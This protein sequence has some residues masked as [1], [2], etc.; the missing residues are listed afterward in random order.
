M[1]SRNNINHGKAIGNSWM[2]NNDHANGTSSRGGYRNSNHN[3]YTCLTYQFRNNIFSRPNNSVTIR[4][5]SALR[6]VLTQQTQ[7]RNG[8]NSNGTNANTLNMVGNGQRAMGNNGA[9][10]YKII[11]YLLTDRPCD[12]KVKDLI[13]Y[14]ESSRIFDL[15]VTNIPPPP[16]LKTCSNLNTQQAIEL[17]RFTTVLTQAACQYPD[18]YVI[19]IKDTSVAVPCIESLEATVL[20]ALQLGEWDFCYLTRWLDR[21]ELYRHPVCV[22]GT[23]TILVETQSPNGTQAIL[24][25]HKGRDV[26]IGQRKMD[27]GLYF[28]PIEVPLG[29]KMNQSIENGFTTAICAVPNQFEFDVFQATTS[30]DLAKLSDCRRPEAPNR[31]SAIPFFWFIV[32]VLGI[33]LIA[34]ALY[35]IGPSRHGNSKKTNTENKNKND[36]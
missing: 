4:P 5:N 33:I 14:L 12:S 7:A 11:V 34:W 27:N 10:I 18:Q 6:D 28:T 20:K 17:H 9:F 31:T 15:R 2:L 3:D 30:A 13:R 25:S 26:I 22:P 21:C 29:T 23:M 24:F 16:T 32:V 36:N 19:V 8:N 35:T 1:L